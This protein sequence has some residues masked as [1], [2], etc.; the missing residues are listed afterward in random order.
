M[1]DK[2]MLLRAE[3]L[4]ACQSMCN[5][6]KYFKKLAPFYLKKCLEA[7]KSAD[8]KN[9]NNVVTC[10]N[11]IIKKTPKKSKSTLVAELIRGTTSRNKLIRK[12]SWQ[13]ICEILKNYTD[14]TKKKTKGLSIN[15]YNIYIK[16]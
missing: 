10:V 7:L 3:C 4:L 2:K 9:A 8:A 15:Y 14:K 16:Y 12:H 11:Y 13:F 6:T 5:H 1:A